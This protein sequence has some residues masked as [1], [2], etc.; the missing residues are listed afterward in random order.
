MLT[1]DELNSILPPDV[2][3]W[4]VEWRLKR[5]TTLESLQG[6]WNALQK[7]LKWLPHR[8]R[9]QAVILKEEIKAK[10][11]TTKET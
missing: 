3:M 6:E 5:L 8:H 1:E 11:L 9:G 4:N 10:L 2:I 7:T